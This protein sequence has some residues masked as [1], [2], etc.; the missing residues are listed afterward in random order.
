MIWFLFYLSCSDSS[1]KQSH[2]E[3]GSQSKSSRGGRGGGRGGYS[4]GGRGGGNKG[5]QKGG[6]SNKETS[7]EDS[8]LLIESDLVSIG[9]VSSYL[10]LTGTL[11]SE[12]A[13]SV[14]P[15]MTGTCSYVYVREGDKVFTGDSLAQISNRSVDASA[16]RAGIELERTRREFSKIEVLYQKGIVSSKDYQEAQSAFQTAKT[17]FEEA[18]NNKGA[19]TITSPIDGVVSIVGVQAGEQVGNAQA[20]QLIDPLHLRLVVAVPERDLLSIHTGQRVEIF[21]AYDESQNIGAEVERVGPIV[22]PANGSVKLFIDIPELEEENPMFRAGQFVRAEVK[23]DTH[24]N[25]TIIPKSALLYQDGQPIVYRV[26]PQKKKE[27]VKDSEEKEENEEVEEVGWFAS[28]FAAEDT[29]AKD[30]A[31]DATT[32][33]GELQEED[34]K[35]EKKESKQPVFV[36]ERREIELGFID[37][38][39]VEILSGLDVGDEIV[40][41]GNT[42]LRSG[43]LIRTKSRMEQNTTQRTEFTE[44]TNTEETNTKEETNTEENTTTDVSSEDK[45][46]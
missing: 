6:W 35:K 9:D 19:T 22:D 2:S 10:Q 31:E 27:E 38:K 29:E 46:Q 43:T 11:E 33:E 45:Q 34:T 7:P 28:W 16:D 24:D 18:Q 23:L 26:A 21:S 37:S 8:A 3:K 36:A 17:S 30:I 12:Y 14:V 32:D 20:F 4:K 1:E 15:E 25:T 40:T 13:V 5:G 41:V 39:F 44:E 42:N